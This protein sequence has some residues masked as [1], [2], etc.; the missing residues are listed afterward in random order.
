[1]DLVLRT[2]QLFARPFGRQQAVEDEDEERPPLFAVT[3]KRVGGDG[4]VT[5]ISLD[6]PGRSVAAV[7][8]VRR[9]RFRSVTEQMWESGS[10][11]TEKP[12][13]RLAVW[14]GVQPITEPFDPSADTWPTHE[15]PEPAAPI[16]GDGWDV[17]M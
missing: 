17:Q 15:R 1:M 9:F 14:N 12:R 11:K 2:I 5:E 8:G 7:D 13:W 3:W 10:Y 4:N 16:S 6:D